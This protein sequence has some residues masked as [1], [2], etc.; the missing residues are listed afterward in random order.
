MSAG[1]PSPITE[2]NRAIT[3]SGCWTVS[4]RKRSTSGWGT[5][6][7]WRVRSPVPGEGRGSGIVNDPNRTDDA[8]YILRLIGNVFSGDLETVEIV[9]GALA[10]GAGEASGG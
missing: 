7:R 10:T 8:Q 5:G 1:F 3:T 6:R 4:S 2:R 9:V